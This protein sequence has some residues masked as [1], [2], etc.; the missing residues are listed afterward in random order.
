ML[1]ISL[2]LSLA[3]PHGT[4]QTPLQQLPLLKEFARQRKVATAHRLALGLDSN[5][6]ES[7]NFQTFLKLCHGPSESDSCISATV[8]TTSSVSSSQSLM[9]L[10]S[11]SS[12]VTEL[13]HRLTA[14]KTKL[15]RNIIAFSFLGVRP[16]QGG[17]ACLPPS[18][19]AESCK[20]NH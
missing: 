11:S 4:A 13:S 18:L 1:V 19:K 2:W 7:E 9:G 3:H 5:V 10:V 15:E 17:A 16:V 8:P 6:W 14:V 12:R 20:P